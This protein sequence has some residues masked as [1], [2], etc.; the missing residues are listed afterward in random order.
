MKA[1]TQY[2][3]TIAGW[4]AWKV[5]IAALVAVA[6]VAGFLGYKLAQVPPTPIVIQLAPAETP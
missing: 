3:L 4:E 6:A 1:D 2:Q 5:F